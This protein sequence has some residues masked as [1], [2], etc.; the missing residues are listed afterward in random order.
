MT[1]GI[2]NKKGPHATMEI[3]I[4]RG[5]RKWPEICAAGYN[6]ASATKMVQGQSS[7]ESPD[8]LKIIKSFWTTEAVCWTLREAQGFNRKMGEA[9][10]GRGELSS[11]VEH[12][13][14]AEHLTQDTDWHKT[15]GWGHIRFY[16][17]TIREPQKIFHQR[18]DTA[19]SVF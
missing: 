12:K 7:Q 16:S 19:I 17:L 1:I 4:E 14:W 11:C 9:R 18:N 3:L 13:T 6:E 8:L 5:D 15:P 10:A 2:T